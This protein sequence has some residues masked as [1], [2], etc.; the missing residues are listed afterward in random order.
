[1]VDVPVTSV[2]DQTTGE[3]SPSHCLVLSVL[4]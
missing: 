1:M 3:D 2:S 4:Q